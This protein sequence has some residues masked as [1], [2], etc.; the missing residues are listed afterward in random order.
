MLQCRSFDQE[1]QN[2]IFEEIYANLNQLCL[3]KNGLCVIKII[4][5]L[6]KTVR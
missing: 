6:T 4:I 3:N 1:K 2:F 5:S